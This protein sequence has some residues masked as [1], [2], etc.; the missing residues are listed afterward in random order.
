MVTYLPAA[1]VDAPLRM[2]ADDDDDILCDADYDS[3]SE[4]LD[5]PEDTEQ[6]TWN[7]DTQ[8]VVGNGDLARDDE[9]WE[10]PVP[11]IHHQSPP[12]VLLPRVQ[13]QDELDR[14]HHLGAAYFEAEDQPL[15]FKFKTPLGSL[16]TSEMGEETSVSSALRPIVRCRSPPLWRPPRCPDLS[17]KPLASRTSSP[18]VWKPE[19]QSVQTSRPSVMQTD[20]HLLPQSST[21]LL[22]APH[23]SIFKGPMGQ[24]PSVSPSTV[25]IEDVL[26]GRVQTTRLS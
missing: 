18:P 9:V 22:L 2:L 8:V 3:A 14:M 26:T 6:F 11:D 16:S 12:A 7:R 25:L 1:Q 13:S 15:Q 21:R 17:D 24:L 4:E 20:R 23:R 19:P 5:P 10:Q